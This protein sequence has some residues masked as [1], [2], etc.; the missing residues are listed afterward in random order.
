MPVLY[1][2]QLRSVVTEHLRA[3]FVIVPFKRW[4]KMSEKANKHAKN[5]CHL[6]SITKMGEFLAGYENPTQTVDTL[7]NNKA[8]RIMEKKES[9]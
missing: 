8:R 1:L 6:F 2:V 5:D 9:D 4:I 7:L 3:Q